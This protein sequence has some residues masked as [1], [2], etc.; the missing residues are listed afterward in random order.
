VLLILSQF[1]E[2]QD[3]IAQLFSARVV[4]GRGDHA[5]FIDRDR[6]ALDP[7]NLTDPA[8]PE[9]RP[10]RLP[11]SPERV[12]RRRT[13]GEG[14]APRKRRDRTL[15]LVGCRLR[16]LRS[17]PAAPGQSEQ[18]ETRNLTPSTP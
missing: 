10:E 12:S 4:G 9:H 13:V 15:P 3:Q 16:H 17:A 11:R 8:R 14:H 2:L 7:V 1:D 5:S 18:V 6:E